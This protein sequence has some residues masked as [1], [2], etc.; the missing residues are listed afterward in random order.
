MKFSTKSKV[1]VLGIK[2]TILGSFSAFLIWEAAKFLAQDLAQ[3]SD[4]SSHTRKMR[5]KKAISEVVFSLL[6]FSCEWK[7]WAVIRGSNPRY[8][9]SLEFP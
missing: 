3:G 1:K 8:K 5:V 2:Y 4:F 7:F 9:S 6:A